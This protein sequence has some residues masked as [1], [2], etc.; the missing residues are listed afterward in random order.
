MPQFKRADPRKQVEQWVCVC[1]C[2]RFKHTIRTYFHAIKM[3]WLKIFES[4]KNKTLILRKIKWKMLFTQ[5]NW[6]Q[7]Q[8]KFCVKISSGIDSILLTKRTHKMKWNERKKKKKTTTTT[9][10]TATTTAAA[11]AKEEKTKCMCTFFHM[12]WMRRRE[13]VTVFL[14]Q[15]SPM[16]CSVSGHRKYYITHSYQC[17]GKYV[18]HR[19]SDARKRS[20]GVY[21]VYRV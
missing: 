13:Q 12:V 11:V 10:A 16:C 5:S 18:D 20:L 4:N 7:L 3:L 6:N 19:W 9:A 2:A 8:W 15:W 1:V 21:T 17:F 14:K